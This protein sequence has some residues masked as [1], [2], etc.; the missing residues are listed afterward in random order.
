MSDRHHVVLLPFADPARCR[1][2]FA[3]AKELPGLRQAAILERSADGVLDVPDNHVRG[4]G[5]PTVGSGVVG[6]LIGLL[7]GPLG[8]LLGF[9]AGAALGNA[10]EGRRELDD[11]AGL[12]VLSAR[13]PDGAALL[14]LDL[15]EASPAPVDQLAADHDVAA[16][17]LSASAFAE[18]VRAAERQAERPA[19]DSPAA[20]DARNPLD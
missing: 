15:D 6:G 20:T 12:I 4:A 13:V 3:Q 7:G 8:M 10:A 1:S 2:A 14:V 17:R 19:G 9:T 16:E 11:M 18:Q 5:V